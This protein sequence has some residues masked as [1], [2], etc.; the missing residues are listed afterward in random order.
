MRKVSVFREVSV[1]QES[2]RALGESESVVGERS[3]GDSSRATDDERSTSE[4]GEYRRTTR[5]HR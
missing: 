1:L 3:K 4:R 2:S 5:E